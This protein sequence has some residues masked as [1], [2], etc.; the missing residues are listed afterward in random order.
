[1]IFLEKSPFSATRRLSRATTDINH[2]GSTHTASTVK[3]TAKTPA[4]SPRHLKKN[5]PP[6]VREVYSPPEAVATLLP[7]A[8]APADLADVE[9]MASP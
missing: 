7:E 9:T 4:L 1:M 8:A 6:R 5:V 3:K 2:G